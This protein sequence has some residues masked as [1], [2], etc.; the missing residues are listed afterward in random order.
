MDGSLRIKVEERGREEE[1]IPLLANR[2]SISNNG[3][4][5]RIRGLRVS[6]DWAFADEYEL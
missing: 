5:M 6:F 4:S 3:S 2:V 1:I